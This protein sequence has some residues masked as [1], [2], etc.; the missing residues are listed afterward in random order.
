MCLT[1]LWSWRLKD[2]SYLFIVIANSHTIILNV[3][4]LLIPIN[5]QTYLDKP[6]AKSCNKMLS[7]DELLV[8]TSY[9]NV[10][11]GSDNIY[12]NPRK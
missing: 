3:L 8:Y 9:C 5:S 6:A 7:I 4:V 1:I 10:N 12:H 11:I 2:Q